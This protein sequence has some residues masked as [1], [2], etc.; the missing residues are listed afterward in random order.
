MKKFILRF[1]KRMQQRYEARQEALE[2]HN[3]FKQH[4]DYVERNREAKRAYK[5]A[6]R[7]L[8]KQ[9]SKTQTQIIGTSNCGSAVSG[10]TREPV[11]RYAN[12]LI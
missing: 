3:W 9:R 2:Y 4:P 7:K 1:I 6:K 8:E 11:K 10:I 12:E 5:L